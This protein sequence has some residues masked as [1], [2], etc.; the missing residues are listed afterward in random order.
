MVRVDKGSVWYQAHVKGGD[1]LSK[2]TGYNTDDYYN[3]YAG[4]DKN[5]IDCL[6]IYY[7]TPSDIRPFK[8][9]KYKV[10]NFA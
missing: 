4:D 8:K 3:G 7:N 1:W 9:A 6:R 10:N 5:P 2:V